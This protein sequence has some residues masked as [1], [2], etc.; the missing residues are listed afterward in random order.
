M[1]RRFIPTKWCPHIDL[2]NFLQH[3]HVREL[4]DTSRNMRHI[5]S[6]IL[7]LLKSYPGAPTWYRNSGALLYGLD[8]CFLQ[9]VVPRQVHHS[10]SSLHSHC[11]VEYGA[12]HGSGWDG[13]ND[14]NAKPFKAM[15]R[16]ICALK[17]RWQTSSFSQETIWFWGAKFG[18][19]YLYWQGLPIFPN[20]WAVDF[21]VLSCDREWQQWLDTNDDTFLTIKAHTHSSGKEGDTVA[22]NRFGYRKGNKNQLDIDN[23]CTNMEIGYEHERYVRNKVIADI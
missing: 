15:R 23:L 20:L 19:T 2:C 8:V 21:H 5:K 22:R 7:E 11:V 16:N 1:P 12:G 4:E 14:W 10:C 18:S 17:I 9:L 3:W 13:G 6:Y